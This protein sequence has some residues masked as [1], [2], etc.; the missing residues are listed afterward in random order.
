MNF[1]RQSGVW[2][3]AAASAAVFLFFFPGQVSA[4]TLAV[5]PG[6]GE[7]SAGQ[8]ISVSVYVSSPDKSVNA[9]SA[10]LSFPAS[11][12]AVTSLNK[13]NSVANLW[14]QE[15]SFSNTAGTVSLEGVILNPG[16]TGDKG[17]VLTINFL[18]KSPGVANV[19]FTNGSVLANDGN[20][21]NILSNFYSA[22]YSI[23]GEA[24]QS[25]TLA[26]T[27]VPLAPEVIS[28]T[29]PD[30]DKWYP[31]SNPQFTWTVP[32]GV[33]AV[34]LLYDKSS[35][36]TP[37]VV[38]AP[39]ISEK[40]LSDVSDGTYY[41]HAQFRNANGWGA[42]THFRFRVDTTPPHRFSIR[43]PGA[44]DP[45]DP[46]PTVAFSTSDD[47]SG[48]D[49]YK[50]KVD[51]EDPLTVP[52]SAVSDTIPYTL[53]L[54]APGQHNLLVQA[55]DQAGNYETAIASFTV[56]ALPAPV[57]TDYPRIIR[58]GDTFAVKGKTIPSATVTVYLDGGK[59]NQ[60]SYTGSSD[61]TGAFT[62]AGDGSIDPGSYKLWVA[63]ADSR[64]ALTAPSGKYDVAVESLYLLKIG[65]FAI[66]ILTV[67]VTIVA[68]LV[69]LLGILWY[70]WR[71]IFGF[72]RIVRKDTQEAMKKVH[73]EF[74]QLRE[75]MRKHIRLLEVAKSKRGL[76]EEEDRILAQLKKDLDRAESVIEKEIE[77][78]K[79][80]AY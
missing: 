47:Q 74:D 63:A 20:G 29:N 14:V 7:F 38:Y 54:Q 18:V 9:V 4:A 52:R 21:T 64:G 53:P 11:L 71:K 49:H 42:I 65:S 55:F 35:I 24:V 60:K 16:F 1:L 30:P 57:V 34:R 10:T 72:K 62:V 70:G 79:K 27:G 56:Q 37:A 15:P 23:G 2:L 26:P 13:T 77:T 66:S 40:S 61:S 41:L 51:A 67:V 45:T 28:P 59:D 58:S 8:R 33:T 32:A 5:N 6:T 43:F 46:R 44:S 3:A 68:L 75:G 36:S 31:V 78:I 76:T 22:S 25:N 69:L 73:K 17:L 50:V 19:T 80:E 12:L 48:L 39:P